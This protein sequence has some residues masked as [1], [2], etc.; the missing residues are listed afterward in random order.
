MKHVAHKLQRVKFNKEY[1]VYKC[2]L[3]G[4]SF[5]INEFLVTGR[6]AICWM[7]GRE[8]V[9]TLKSGRLLK[10]HCPDCRRRVNVGKK[11]EE[12]TA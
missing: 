2:V 11:I 3:P 8:F 5:F 12:V 7:C 4:C 9:M 10:P 1:R 6:I